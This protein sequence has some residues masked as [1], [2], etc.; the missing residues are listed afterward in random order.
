[1][2]NGTFLTLPARALL[3]AALAFAPAAPAAA[4]PVRAQHL[5]AELVADH[6]A[7]GRAGA[8]LSRSAN[9][10]PGWHT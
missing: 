1:M 6:T 2:V 9:M 10:T 7:I 4:A 5:T 8:S 3:L